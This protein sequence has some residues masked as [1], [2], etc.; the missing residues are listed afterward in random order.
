MVVDSLRDELVAIAGESVWIDL[1][2][3]L[4]QR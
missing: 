3:R 2:I 4:D 1:R